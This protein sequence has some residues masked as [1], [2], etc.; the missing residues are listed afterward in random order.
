MAST[1]ADIMQVMAQEVGRPQLFGPGR[2]EGQGRNLI[3]MARFRNRGYLGNCRG[4][5]ERIRVW[6]EGD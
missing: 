6:R 2:A 4:W 1:T 3:R 5:T